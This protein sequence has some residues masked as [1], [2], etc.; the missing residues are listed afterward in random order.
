M[1]LDEIEWN[2]QYKAAILRRIRFY[3]HLARLKQSDL[4]RKIQ[5]S[6]SAIGQIETGRTMPSIDTLLLIARALD[7]K[8]HIL[9][10]PFSEA[11]FKEND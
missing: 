6:Q 4:A 5:V 9:F 1:T 11:I 8:P 2:A 7:I 10:L 3:R